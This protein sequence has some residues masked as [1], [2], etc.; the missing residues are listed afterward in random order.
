MD[1]YGCRIRGPELARRSRHLRVSSLLRLRVQ[2]ARM[3]AVP[4]MVRFEVR[5]GCGV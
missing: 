3:E 2:S 4:Q 1:N 5:P